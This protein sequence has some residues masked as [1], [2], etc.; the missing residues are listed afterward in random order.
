MSA[1][2]TRLFDQ[3]PLSKPRFRKPD[4][5]SVRPD[6]IRHNTNYV[7]DPKDLQRELEAFEAMKRADPGAI[8]ELRM[9]DGRL[10]QKYVPASVQSPPS[11]K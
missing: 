7:S 10:I 1:E 6:G 2:G 9:P 5:S 11:D 4:V 3:N 8:H